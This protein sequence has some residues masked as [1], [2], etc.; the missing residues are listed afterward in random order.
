[1]DH[2]VKPQAS[3]DDSHDSRGDDD[4]RIGVLLVDDHAVVREGLRRILAQRADIVIVGEAS[5]GDEALELVSRRR[6]EVVIMDLNMPGMD[7]LETTRR[8]CADHAGVRVVIFT[9]H[10]GLETFQNARASGASGVILKDITA[11][12]ISEAV[13]QIAEG[14]PYADPRIDPDL[15]ADTT[16]LKQHLLSVREQQIL[17]LLADGCTNRDVCER[18]LLGSETVKTHVSHILTKLN[19]EH[20]SQAVAIGMREGLIR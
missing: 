3:R 5:N 8:I 9:G 10:A 12:A 1:M 18:L 13:A 19:A 7:G 15:A 2:V 17:Q 14:R 4:R 16:P 11:Q 20:R 6:P